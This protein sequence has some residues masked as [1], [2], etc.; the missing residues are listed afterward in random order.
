MKKFDINK[1]YNAYIG[2][3]AKQRKDL[4]RQLNLLGIP[5][6]KIE[7]YTYHETPG[8]KHLFFYL[9]NSS[10]IIPYYLLPEEQLNAIQKI[11]LN[12]KNSTIDH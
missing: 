1:V 10:I 12:Y 9:K 2:L 4:I 3:N 11:I 6:T 5:V 8:I 7:A